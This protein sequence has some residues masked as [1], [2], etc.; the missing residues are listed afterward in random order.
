M[1]PQNN[2][3]QSWIPQ[4]GMPHQP[5]MPLQPG[6][7]LQP[8]MPHPQQHYVQ[9][10][11][12]PFPT[13]QQTPYGNNQ[14]H[15]NQFNERPREGMGPHMG[16]M[17][18]FQ[19][20]QPNQIFQKHEINPQMAQK[21]QQLSAFKIVFIFDDSG[22]MNSINQDSNNMSTRWDEFLQFANTSI[23]IASLFNQ[24]GSDVHFLNRPPIRNVRDQS[25]LAH[26]FRDKPQGVTPLARTIQTVINENQP[27]VLNG[28]NL[29]LVI[30]T[31]GEPTDMNG[32]PNIP[33]FKQ[34][35]FNRPANVFTTIVA[36][37]SDQ[38]SVGYLNGLD[39]ELPRLDVVDDYRSEF[40]EIKR[41]KGPQFPFSFGDYIAKSFL[42]SID[43]EMDRS[44]E[45]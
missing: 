22:S 38:Q 24:Q 13:Q 8:G 7:Q 31:D 11:Q 1:N 32:Y 18:G 26:Y 2:F 3:A 34:C 30:A 33:E 45:Y 43:P 5:G 37:T 9:N 28:K 15:N 39:K 20:Q 35:L 4:P 10:Q 17:G 16:G 25:Q 19:Q 41:A 14:P 36:C 29:L 42:G 12:M 44:D 6:M 27:N 23:E 21:L 40:A